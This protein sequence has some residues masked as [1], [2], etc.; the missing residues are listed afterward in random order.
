[1]HPAF[2]YLPGAR[3]AHGEL[4]ACRL[5]GHLVDLGEGYIPADLV[6]TLSTRAASVATL[7][8]PALAASGPSA[9]WIHGSGDEPPSPHHVHRAV[10]HRLRPNL[11]ARV[12]F[13]DAFVPATDLVRAGSVLVMSPLRTMIDLALGLHR[14][15]RLHRWLELF[16]ADNPQLVPAAANVIARMQRVPGSRT[17]R[18]VL[19]QLEV[20][21]M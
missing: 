19:A 7:I 10:D 13:H 20:T 14:D 11:Q 17:G 18:G 3:L 4:S 2:L 8:P 12:V 5:D 16:A 1:M 9:A 15:K 21:K 6:E